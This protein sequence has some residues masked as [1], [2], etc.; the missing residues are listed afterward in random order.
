MLNLFSSLPAV[1]QQSSMDC[2]AAC[3][4][5]ICRYHGKRVSL[6]SMHITFYAKFSK[7]KVFKV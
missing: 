7:N 5:T 6:N 4:A 2:G 1:R 3:L